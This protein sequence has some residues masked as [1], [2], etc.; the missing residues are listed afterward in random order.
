MW[1]EQTVGESDYAS[2]MTVSLCTAEGGALAQVFAH[3]VGFMTCGLCSNWYSGHS[4]KYDNGW[5][6]APCN[7]C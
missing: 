5:M 4:G 6:N 7:Q 2:I 1:V 3:A